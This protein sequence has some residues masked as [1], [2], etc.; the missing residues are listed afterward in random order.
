MEENVVEDITDE[1]Q[2]W[3]FLTDYNSKANALPKRGE[4]DFEPDGTQ[5][6]SAILQES[7]DAMYKALSGERKHSAKNHVTATWFKNLGMAKVD[8]VRSSHFS[9]MGKADSN[10]VVWLLPEEVVYLVERGSMECWYP[11]GVPMTLQAVYA[12]CIRSPGDLERL[13]VFS[14]LKKAGFIVLRAGDDLSTFNPEIVTKGFNLREYW[15]SGLQ[16]LKKMHSKPRTFES[17]FQT[18]ELIPYHRPPHHPVT[19]SPNKGSS[20]HRIDFIAWKPSAT[21]FKKTN[22]PPPDYYI[23]VIDAREHSMPDLSSVERLFNSVP[24]NEKTASLTQTQRLKEGWRNVILSIV[25]SGLISFF[26]I[27]DISFGEEKVYVKP[28]KPKPRS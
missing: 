6:Q 19:L 12:S 9:S 4:K 24:V 28:P 3:R 21:N 8:A 15:Q 25:D 5:V 23:S 16:L 26:K 20:L 2:D 14:Y 22:P 13:Q 11:E 10:G 7:R 17:M 1:A 27:S 18:L